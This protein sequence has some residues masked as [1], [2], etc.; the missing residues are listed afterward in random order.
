MPVKETPDD[1]VESLA[2]TELSP[3]SDD[4]LALR[5]QALRASEPSIKLYDAAIRPDAS[6]AAAA[7]KAAWTAA[8]L[9]GLVWL[10]WAEPW[11]ARLPYAARLAVLALRGVLLV[12]AFGYFYHRFFQHLGWLTR[13]A[14]WF[15]RNQ[16]FHW[17]HH[18]ILYP[19]GRFYQRA[20]PYISSEG[21]IGISWLAPA[22]AVI[23]LAVWRMG[24]NLGTLVFC[25]SI[26]S[27]AYFVVDD[28]HERFHLMKHSY[29]GSRYFKW[30][31]DIHVLHHWDQRYNFTIVHPLMDA[32]FGTY[33]SP[34]KHR[35]ELRTA[36][37][38]LELT[39]SDLINWRYLLLEATPAEYAAF[40][41]EAK[42]HPRSLRK[43]GHLM[44]V[45]HHVLVRRPDDGLAL[46]LKRRAADLLN[47]VA[48]AAAV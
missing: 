8:G 47:L 19:I 46:L 38:D 20:V 48:P 12:E 14:F 37:E 10:A 23:A 4:L 9:C 45:L 41:S 27:Y 33:L 40:I 34:A 16:R 44:E 22:L 43:L 31:E 39:V 36:I 1:V 29:L 42:R 28:V 6:S 32:L 18:M 26:A 7:L 15:R 5:A 35:R 17:M 2:M 25:A 24:A 13:R 11:S 3:V 30:L 21:G